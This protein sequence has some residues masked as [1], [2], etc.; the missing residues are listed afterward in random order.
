M[1][2]R[3]EVPVTDVMLHE[4]VTDVGVRKILRITSRTKVIEYA[5]TD[6]L[7]NKLAGSAGWFKEETGR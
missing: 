2:E 7:W 3:S 1:E 6:E 5:F 4:R